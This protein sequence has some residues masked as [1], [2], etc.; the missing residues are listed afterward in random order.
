MLYSLI[1]IYFIYFKK[2]RVMKKNLMGSMLRYI[3]LKVKVF[4]YYLVF[5]GLTIVFFFL[6]L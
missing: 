2:N 1:Y 4:L 3:F 5:I 6:C